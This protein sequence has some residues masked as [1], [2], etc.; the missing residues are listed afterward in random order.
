HWRAA[1]M[2]GDPH[3][4][5]K[6]SVFMRA[7]A[8]ARKLPEG[9][10]VRLRAI[11]AL[12]PP[13]LAEVIADEAK[14]DPNWYRTFLRY[15]DIAPPERIERE[16][17]LHLADPK[18]KPSLN[19]LTDSL[20]AAVDGYLPGHNLIAE[21]YAP[22]PQPAPLQQLATTHE[23]RLRSILTALAGAFRPDGTV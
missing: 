20:Q 1:V 21:L 12:L 23:R 19:H 16:W 6:D 15:V 7:I 2:Q 9:H 8:Y 11:E 13:N 14:K 18:W 5:R 4:L 3:P 10:P 17:T 22:K